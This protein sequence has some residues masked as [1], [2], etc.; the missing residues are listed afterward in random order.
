LTPPSFV[1]IYINFLPVTNTIRGTSK[2]TFHLTIGDEEIT[3][4]EYPF[5]MEGK[6]WVKGKTCKWV[7]TFTTQAMELAK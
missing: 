1:L 7:R 2:A 3:T 5:Y 6:G 4:L